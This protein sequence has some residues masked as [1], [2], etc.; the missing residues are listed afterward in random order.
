VT[1]LLRSA[2][3]LS[4]L[5]LLSGPG[6]L[7]AQA[8]P[9]DRPLPPPAARAVYRSHW[10]DLLNALQENDAAA[11]PAAL[12][13]MTKAARAVGIE[14]LSDFSRMAVHEARRAEAAGR[15]TT[16]RPA[17]DAAVVLDDSSFDA[18][19]SRTGFLLRNGN[20]GEG[21][22]GSPGAVAKIFA[23]A[24][25]RLTFG[26]WLGI[27]AVLSVAAAALACLLGLFLKHFRRILHDLQELASR[28]FGTRTAK[29]IAV[30]LVAL[31]LFVTLGPLW[32][33]LYW[34]VLAFAYSTRRER[35]V[36]AL[37]LVSL[38][39]LPIF[40]DQ[41]ARE[42]LIRRA[43]LHRAAVDLSE[44]RE[45]AST[46]DA[47]LAAATANPAGG[48]EWLLLGM[49]AERAGDHP[50]AVFAY[51]K[52]IQTNPKENRAFVNRGNVHFAEGDFSE[53]IADYEEA[54]RIAP[55]AAESFYN[56][57]VARAEIYDFKGQEAARARAL[58][59]SSRAVDMW[60]SNPPL[61]RVVPAPYPVA[62]ARSRVRARMAETANLRKE[63]VSL[64][65]SPWCL[66]PW[67]ALVLAWGFGALRA[68][69]GLASE[70][71][72]CGRPFCR[73]CKR[74]GGPAIYCGRCVRLQN[75][76]ETVSEAARE[77]DTRE[78]AVRRRRRR[79]VVLASTLVA[80]GV[81]RFLRDKPYVAA[82]TLL[83][84]F[85][86]LAIALGGPGVFELAPLAPRSAA[87]A[88]RIA[89]G[90]V[91]LLLWAW[92]LASAWRQTRE[93]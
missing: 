34:S 41:L 61:E 26:S 8:A 18:A 20:I 46:E 17:Y 80:P 29:P 75:R 85:L 45:D 77:E 91:A 42:N 50:R 23:S 64:V 28:A 53:A 1:R 68:R 2:A 32:L 51:G 76:K 47:L 11:I 52:A 62:R 37:A 65:T 43:P 71:A 58:Q 36:I 25:S 33:L 86:V 27:L 92:A 82:G 9:P 10:F 14:R 49:Y 55:N 93:S 30:V 63:L 69:R 56:L 31:P 88:G 3:A 16:A 12:D 54:S 35:V 83:L 6:S 78:S 13:A 89:A 90:A 70:C 24:E 74:Y 84:F 59:V 44:H 72:R 19:A 81:H 87:F 21:I 40:V 7:G 57:S 73:I 66:A 60:S 22:A 15:P 5:V 39:I 38:G 4:V 48:D 67:G 79:F